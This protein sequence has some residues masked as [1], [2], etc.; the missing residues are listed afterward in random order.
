[1]PRHLEAVTRAERYYTNAESALSYD[2]VRNQKMQNWLNY[3]NWKFVCFFGGIWG[4][5]G[6][7]R[8]YI[9]SALSRIYELV[10]MGVVGHV[11]ICAMYAP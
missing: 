9:V 6:L 10:T 3:S 11:S 1:M 8:Y 7:L 2:L 4:L 5:A